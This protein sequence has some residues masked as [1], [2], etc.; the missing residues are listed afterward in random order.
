MDYYKRTPVENVIS[1]S[2]FISF[3]YFEYVK[4]FEGIGEE[5]DFWEMV[6]I[7]Y[8]Y[9][10]IISDDKVYFLSS[11]EAFLHTPNEH[12]NI[13]STGDFASAF[14]FSFDCDC[15][16]LSVI[17]SRVLR[18]R[19]EETEIIKQLY[20]AGQNA[21]EGP[22]DIFDLQKLIV[23][24]DIPYGGIQIVKNMLEWLLAVMINNSLKKLKSAESGNKDIINEQLIADKVVEIVQN[25]VYQKISLDDV[26][27]QLS[28]SKSY[29]LKVF[30]EQTGNSVMEYYKQ[31]RIKEAKRLIS[32]GVYTFTQIARLLHFSSV[33]HF[34]SS[35]KQLTGMT[36]S[37]YQKSVKSRNVI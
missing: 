10:K 2:S 17:Q 32:E 7:D 12:H 8:G 6:Y 14:I 19:E 37:G 28:F 4:S 26:C 24:K 34:S 13:I 23:K 21:F 36:P 16:E 9:V 20:A 25:S 1:V 3:H 27:N 18:L 5:H 35:F 29:I 22:Y 11:G 30:R 33:H 15:K 31:M